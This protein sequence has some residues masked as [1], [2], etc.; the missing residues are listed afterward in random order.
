[1]AEPKR[2]QNFKT[3][4]L[5]FKNKVPYDSLLDFYFLLACNITIFD[6]KTLKAKLCLF[7]V[8]ESRRKD[9]LHDWVLYFL[10]AV[11]LFTDI[12]TRVCQCPY[13]FSQSDCPRFVPRYYCLRFSSLPLHI[14]NIVLT[15]VSFDIRLFLMLSFN[16]V[17]IL[18]CLAHLLIICMKRILDLSTL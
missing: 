2:V 5:S 15:K 9:Y 18:N 12:K 10:E 3:A 16:S 1:M 11:V 6:L 7:W 4:V 14:S 13:S 17:S 8:D